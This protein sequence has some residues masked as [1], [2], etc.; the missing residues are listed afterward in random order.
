[1]A[2]ETAKKI[3][4]NQKEISNGYWAGM[5]HDVGK[6]LISK[7]IL[8]KNGSLTDQEYLKIKKHPEWAYRTL[9]KSEQLEDIAEYVLYHHERWDGNGY[10]E[11]I[12]GDDI[13]I[14]SRILTVVDAWDAMRS[15]R[16]YRNALTKEMAIEELRLNKGTQFDGEVVDVFLEVIGCHLIKSGREE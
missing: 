14:I 5:V 15:D 7:R 1:L 12:E 6:L 16:S 2:S 10:P 9:K 8:T 4:L 11:E 13:P 3:G